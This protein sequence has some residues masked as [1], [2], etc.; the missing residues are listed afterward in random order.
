M[1]FVSFEQ[2]P[3]FELAEDLISIWFASEFRLLF[4]DVKEILGRWLGCLLSKF[5]P[6]VVILHFFVILG[7]YF[8]TL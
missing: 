4:R 2:C 8:L 6:H 5:L 7:K 3:E 1:S